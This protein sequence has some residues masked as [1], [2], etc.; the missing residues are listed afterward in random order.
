LQQIAGDA[1]ESTDGT[2]AQALAE[3]EE[4][5]EEEI[6]EDQEPQRPEQES[7]PTAEA[8]QSDDQPGETTQ[9]TESSEKEEK[10]L[11]ISSIDT[12][13]EGIF[14]LQKFFL[15][16][17]D[18]TIPELSRKKFKSIISVFKATTS[19]RSRQAYED[20]TNGTPL[21]Y[22]ERKDMENIATA[23]LKR[24]NSRNFTNI[25]DWAL[26]C[27]RKS[28]VQRDEQVRESAF[29]DYGLHFHEEHRCNIM[30]IIIDKSKTNVVCLP[31][32]VGV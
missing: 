26:T 8:E 27:M 13:G 32:V 25:R 22:L 11:K 29:S 21:S 30:Y 7:E 6:H 20:K 18:P 14:H 12:I 28:F 23:F 4:A 31:V 15:S 10:A 1:E 3:A 19:S 16:I 2:G 5:E 17:I 9:P 24:T